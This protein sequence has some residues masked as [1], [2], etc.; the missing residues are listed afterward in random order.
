[1]SELEEIAKVRRP[2]DEE[3]GGLTS[4]FPFLP[5]CLLATCLFLLPDHCSLHAQ[6]QSS[7]TPVRTFWDKVAAKS[8]LLSSLEVKCTR[9]VMW[10]LRS[11]LRLDAKTSL[12]WLGQDSTRLEADLLG[13]YELKFRP[14]P[15]PC[16]WHIVLF[17][18][19]FSFL[20]EGSKLHDCAHSCTHLLAPSHGQT[21]DS[22]KL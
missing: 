1:M 12:C 11:R 20:K 6:Q 7:W 19:L 2:K 14:R 8:G 13:S 21:D 15:R 5:P 3:R 22:L 16:S 10:S 4:H 18:I 17:C 9:M